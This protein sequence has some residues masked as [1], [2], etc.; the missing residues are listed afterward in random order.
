MV[1]TRLL[2]IIDFLK[3]SVYS[4]YQNSEIIINYDSTEKYL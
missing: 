3:R 4:H 2:W 1:E